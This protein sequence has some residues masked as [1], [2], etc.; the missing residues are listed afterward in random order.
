V[1][2]LC[3]AKENLFRFGID[4]MHG[5]DF[6]TATFLIRL[7]FSAKINF[8]KILAALIKIHPLELN[9]NSPISALV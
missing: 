1:R 3:S 6:A 9:G 5:I 8:A 7:K 4:F 2:A